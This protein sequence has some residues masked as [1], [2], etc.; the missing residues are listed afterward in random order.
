MRNARHGTGKPTGAERTPCTRGVRSALP[1][2]D[3]Q[4]GEGCGT[5]ALPEG[6]GE[7][8]QKFI[9]FKSKYLKPR[10]GGKHCLLTFLRG[11]AVVVS[12]RRKRH[13]PREGR[14]TRRRDAPMRCATAKSPRLNPSATLRRDGTRPIHAPAPVRRTAD[15]KKAAK[16]VRCLD[17]LRCR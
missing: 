9:A 14:T 4:H 3:K 10:P 6:C 11:I 16:T 1:E 8:S 17:L 15:Q 12:S 13:G 2:K 5:H 7:H